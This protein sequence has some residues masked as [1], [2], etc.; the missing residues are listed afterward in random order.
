VAAVAESLRRR[1]L[2]KRRR[3]RRCG[4]G[5]DGGKGQCSAVA[6]AATGEAAYS[7]PSPCSWSIHQLLPSPRHTRGDRDDASGARSGCKVS[8]LLFTFS[9][10]LF[11]SLSVANSNPI[12]FWIYSLE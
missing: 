9:V 11:N 2:G 7:R 1:A 5:G 3:G 12:G 8:C 4:G 10:S 6:S